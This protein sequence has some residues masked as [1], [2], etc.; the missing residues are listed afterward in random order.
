MEELLAAVRAGGSGSLLVVGEAGV[1][2]SALLERLAGSAAE[3]QV[4]RAVGVEGEVDLPYAGL[5]QL[6]RSMLSRIEVLPQPQ[7]DALR[8]VF[9]LASGQAADRYLVGLAVLSLMSEA[10]A[11]RPLLCVVD[12]AQCSTVRPPMRLRS[13]RA[14]SAPIRSG[15]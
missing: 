10:A 9:G 13:W 8:V 15:W 3:C 12:D 2:K 11:A 4:V 14:G 1:G 7:A 6:C 5:H